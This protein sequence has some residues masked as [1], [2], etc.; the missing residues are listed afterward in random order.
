M[1]IGLLCPYS[2]SVPGGVQGQVSGLARA[3]QS[4][5]HE[6]QVFSPTGAPVRLKANGSVAPV[7]LSPLDALRVERAMRRQH[8]EVV[9]LHEPMAPVLS[10]ACLARHPVP[11]VGTYHRAGG[12]G[13]YTAMGPLAR[14]ANDRLDARCAVSEAAAETARAA[15]GGTYQVLFNGVEVDRFASA[16][17]AP[18]AGPTILF[19]GRHEARKGL[20]VLLAAFA[21]V[22]ADA[23]TRSGG[24]P[25]LWVAGSGPETQWLQ[26][27]HPASERLQWLG[28]LDEDALASHL[29]GADVLCAPSLRGESFGMVLLEAMAAGTVVVASDLPGYRAAAGGH[30]ALVPPGDVH[31]L[32]TGLAR[33][34]ADAERGSGHSSP[35]ARLAA[36]AH[37]EEWSMPRLATRYLDVYRQAIERW[38]ERRSAV[39]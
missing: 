30:A 25:V 18:T 16:E 20:D 13:W 23:G 32:A 38:E 39:A 17:P 8:Y 12:T 2:L 19:V 29:A 31:A 10:Y 35:E 9:H 6:A 24:G 7:T 1:R 14:W 3:L 4:M 27:R 36:A 34:L 37:V 11:M 26:R 22:V 28:V 15:M 21:E 33:A 5:G